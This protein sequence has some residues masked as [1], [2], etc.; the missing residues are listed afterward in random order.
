MEN[1]VVNI[2]GVKYSLVDYES[3]SIVLPKFEQEI[4]KYLQPRRGEVFTD[5]GAHVGKYTLQVAKR[6]GR[7]GLVV[8]VEPNPKNFLALLRGVELNDLQNVI[9]LN[10][11]AWS[12]N[13]KLRMFLGDS[14]GHHSACKNTGFGY[15]EVE[16]KTIDDILKTLN[17]EHVDWIKIDV[18]GAEFEVLKGMGKTLTEMHP[19]II[20]EAF[21]ENLRD[22]KNLLEKHGY[23]T[24]LIKGLKGLKFNYYYFEP[25]FTESIPRR[26]QIQQ[27]MC[28]DYF[29]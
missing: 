29:I 15:F 7:Y 23:K 18:E 16:A 6:L 21:H 2:S 17:I 26:G 19:R 3:L 8:A 9:S 24:I 13:C 4:W 20:I 27:S 12:Q 25:E 11:A 5:I 10:C 22:I 28:K 14:S 1:R